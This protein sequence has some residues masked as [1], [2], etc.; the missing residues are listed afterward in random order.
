M[1]QQFGK[2]PIQ[3]RQWIRHVIDVPADSGWAFEWDGMY[4]QNLLYQDSSNTSLQ[5]R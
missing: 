1:A 2:V 4:R 3:M 5:A